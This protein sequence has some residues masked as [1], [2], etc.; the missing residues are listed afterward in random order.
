MTCEHCGV[1]LVIGDFPFCPHGRGQATVVGDEMDAIIENNGTPHPIRFRSK[2]ALNA[3][4]HAHGLI[5]KVRHVPENAG[6]DYSPHTTDWSR[7]IDPQTL[8]N[9]RILLSRGG[10]SAAAHD[11]PAPSLPVDLTI[12]VLETGIKGTYVDD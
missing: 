11:A 1:D 5:A 2:A 9:V 4:M 7:G 3:H 12:R 10:T 6:T 8:E